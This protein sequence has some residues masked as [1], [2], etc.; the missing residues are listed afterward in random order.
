[1]ALFFMLL[2]KHFDKDVE[3][4]RKSSVFVRGNFK[5]HQIYIAQEILKKA[6]FQTL[7]TSPAFYL[8]C[9]VE[10]VFVLITKFGKDEVILLQFFLK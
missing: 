6:G 10:E 9:L 8:V 5:S 7:F 2:N 4:S 1:M 3:K